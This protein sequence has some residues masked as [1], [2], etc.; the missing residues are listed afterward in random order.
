M[1]GAIG[2]QDVDVAFHETPFGQGALV[3][4]NRDCCISESPTY[5]VFL[6]DLTPV[7]SARGPPGCERS[8]RSPLVIQCWIGF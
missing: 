5:G 1:C 6:R 3:K 7:T 4:S 8:F 2:R